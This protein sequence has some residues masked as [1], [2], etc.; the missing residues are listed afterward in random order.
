[1]RNHWYSVGIEAQGPALNADDPR[2][3]DLVDA[4]EAID[5]AS[6]P[7]VSLG[8][9]ANGPGVRLSVQAPDP[10]AG[11]ALAIE[12]FHEG[13]DKAGIERHPIARLETMTEEFLDQW[14]AQ[15]GTQY[16]GV[17][18][19]ATILGVSKQRVYELRRKPEFPKPVAELAAGPV[20]NRVTLNNF[21]ESWDRKP[22]RPSK[23]REV[24]RLS[25]ARGAGPRVRRARAA[26]SA[27]S[28]KGKRRS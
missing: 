21:I 5:R 22:G 3:D 20:W 8:G 25:R 14:L 10:V 2:I 9:L 6:G 26:V 17:A 27:R 28:A 16:V 24:I 19:I 11:T 13:L 18:E 7:V 4:L 23:D 1:M 12:V 15:P